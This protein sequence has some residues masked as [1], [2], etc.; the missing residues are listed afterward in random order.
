VPHYFGIRASGLQGLRDSGTQG[1]RDSGTQGR[2]NDEMTHLQDFPPLSKDKTDKTGKTDKTDKK[3]N[4]KDPFT[5]SISVRN[6]SRV[7]AE[8]REGVFQCCGPFISD[9]YI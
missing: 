1:L 5:V 6:A 7:G 2:R 4:G 3:D 9:I 8:S